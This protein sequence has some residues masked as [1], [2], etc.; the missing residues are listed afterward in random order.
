MSENTKHKSEIKFTIEL[1]ENNMPEKI[2]W[3]ASQTNL[4]EKECRA[5][6]I[7][8]W[9]AAEKD[10]LKFDLWTKDM[11]IDEMHQHF[12]ITLMS[13]AESYEKAVNTTI[14]VPE[15]QAFCQMLYKK[16]KEEESQ[17]SSN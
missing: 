7:S 14:A 10:T 1:D 2:T 15:M 8:I 12:M 17:R 16:V 9:D 13:L 6:N 4:P 11:I 5:I 3:L